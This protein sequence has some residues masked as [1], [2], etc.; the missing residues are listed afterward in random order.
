MWW[1]IMD[2]AQGKFCK[3]MLR[4]PASVANGTVKSGPEK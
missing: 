2:R 3:N 1:E 4:I